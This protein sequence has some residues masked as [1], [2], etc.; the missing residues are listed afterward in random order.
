[1][2]SQTFRPPENATG[3][4]AATPREEWARGQHRGVNAAA[5]LT[6]RGPSGPAVVRP[7]S[8]RG[9]L[10]EGATIIVAP[11]FDGLG[12]RSG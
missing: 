3:R 12:R 4:A 7:V 10:A 9:S 2:P 1:M 11:S 5:L 6:R 8:A